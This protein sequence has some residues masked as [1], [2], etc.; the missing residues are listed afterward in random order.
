MKNIIRVL[1]YFRP[2]VPRVV[3]VLGLMLL[4]TGANLIKPWPIAWIVDHLLGDK[5]LPRIL[6]EPLAAWPKSSVLAFLAISIFI[7]YALHAVLSMGQNYLVIK[8]GLRGLERVRNELFDWLQRLSLRYHQGASQGDLIYRASWDTYSFQTLFQHGL[9][10]FLSAILT[11]TLMGIVM[12]RLNRLM[13]LLALGTVP[14]LLLSMEAFGRMMRDRTLAAQAADS[15]VTAL[16]QQSIVA[17][18]LTQSY[19]R[20][21]QEQARFTAQVSQAFRSRLAQHGSEV[22][23]LALMALIFGSAMAGTAW[24][25]ATLVM[26]G[27]LTVG[28]LLIFLAYLGQVYEPLN[29]LS[30]V[31]TTVSTAR[32]GTQRVFEILDSP[33]EVKDRPGA[34]P[35]VGATRGRETSVQPVEG[36]ASGPLMVRGAIDFDRVSFQYRPDRPTL[37]DISFRVEPGET[38]AIVGP[39]GAGKSTLAHFLPRFFDPSAGVVR[40]DGVDLREL[41]LKDLR[42]QIALVMQEPLLLPATIAE[43]IGFGHPAAGREQIEAAA[44]AAHADAFIQQLPQKYDTPVGEGAVRLSVG[45]KQRLSLARAFL[46]DAPVLVLDEPT[47]ALDSESEALVVASLNEL[48]RHRTTLIVAHRLP[49][50]RAVDRVL[51][52][53]NG[54]LTAC[55]TPE[56]VIRAG[57]YFAR[58]VSAGET[59][60]TTS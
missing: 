53:E 5:P 33:E 58:M 34:R 56:E 23:Y 49:T 22:A 29:Q 15:R 9:F 43:N 60:E 57:G 36:A 3:A 16:V 52:L 45:E 47:S 41:R 20:E 48:M 1:G 14:L 6:A 11:L 35:V 31:G 50:I 24:L 21:S 55:G 27:N 40:L 32:A 39:S 25:G 38:V 19:A 12:W 13:A 28:Q 8:V 4:S 42:S 37:R 2:D 30:N 59:H 18:P 46:K 44:R 54:R 26:R 10:T 51:V 17:L 7:I